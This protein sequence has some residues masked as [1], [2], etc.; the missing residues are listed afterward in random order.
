MIRFKCQNKSY[1]HLGRN[2]AVLLASISVVPCAAS[3]TMPDR[4]QI[5]FEHGQWEA[6]GCT[7]DARDCS[8]EERSNETGTGPVSIAHSIEKKIDEIQCYRQ[9]RSCVVAS[10]GNASGFLYAEIQRFS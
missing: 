4:R 5:V 1:Y 7:L 8:S 3:Q 6:I 9:E 10:A 2:L